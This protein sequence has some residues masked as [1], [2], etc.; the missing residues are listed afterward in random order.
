[1]EELILKVSENRLL[2]RLSGAKRDE[3]K[4]SCRKLYNEELLNLYSSLSIIK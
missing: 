2:R 1:M 3:L 4:E